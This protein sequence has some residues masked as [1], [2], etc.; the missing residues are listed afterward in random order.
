ME[1]Q[2]ATARGSEWAPGGKQ[3]NLVATSISDRDGDVAAAGPAYTLGA[4]DEDAV[5]ALR[6]P[7]DRLTDATW[8][9]FAA[10]AGGS[11]Q[12]QLSHLRARGARNLGRGRTH[13]LELVAKHDGGATKIGQCAVSQCGNSFVVNDG[14]LLLPEAQS[15][16]APAMESVLRTLGPGQYEYGGLWN[17]EPPREELLGTIDGVTVSEARRFF[18]QGV[19][20]SKWPSWER[21]WAKVSDSV[22]YESKYAPER[23]PGLRLVRYRG[24]AMLKAIKA[25][26]DLQKASYARKGLGYNRLKHGI[27]YAYYIARC[28]PTLELVLAVADE[29][30][31]AAY[32]G[33]RIGAN[34]Y[35]I[36]GGQAAGS[37][38]ANW[39]LLKEMT[40]AAF[41]AAPSSRFIMGYV[42]YAMHD[43]SVG[44]GLLRARRAL[45]ASDFETSMVEFDYRSA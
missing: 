26:V 41:E 5:T 15:L 44:G 43:E 7:R 14:L 36:Y 40:R 38:G 31:L 9:A 17:I 4:A 21:Y 13:Y 19:D 1:K 20:F 3:T 27:H 6:I 45:R 25:I 35:Y 37:S 29:G 28:A 2:G 18:V 39:Y 30:V 11:Y 42:D 32:Y 12:V 24:L 34:T 33:S 23:V 10:R 22:R 8:D 16:F